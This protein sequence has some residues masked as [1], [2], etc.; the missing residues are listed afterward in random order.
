MPLDLNIVT[1]IDQSKLSAEAKAA[2]GSGT[3]YV[4]QIYENDIQFNSS[5][6]TRAIDGAQKLVQGILKILLTD[7]K[8]HLE[9]PAYGTDINQYF[10][11]KLTNDAFAHIRDSVY[12]CLT[13]YNEIATPGNPNKDEIISVVDEIRVVKD[14]EDPRR[15]FIYISITTQLGTAV[16]V[17]LMKVV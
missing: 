1:K 10:G 13:H 5:K 9:D 2:I 11:Q 4:F 3:D 6:K 17:A 7:L 15:I 16:R 8:S 12:S 14:D